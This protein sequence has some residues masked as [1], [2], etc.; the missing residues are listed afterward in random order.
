MPGKYPLD[1]VHYS[2]LAVYRECPA[3]FKYMADG[4]SK[5]S[6]QYM[7]LGSVFHMAVQDCVLNNASAGWLRDAQCHEFWIDQFDTVS[8]LHPGDAY[9]GVDEEVIKDWAHK[10]VN[11]STYYGETIGS[12]VKNLCDWIRVGFGAE[13]IASELEW[14]VDGEPP[15]GGALD[16][17]LRDK[18]NRRIIADVK[19]SGLWNRLL[20]DKSV[21]KQSL[22]IAQVLHHPQL[23]MYHWG[24]WQSGQYALHEIEGYAIIF[25]ANLVPYASGAK[26]GQMRGSPMQLAYLNLDSYPAVQRWSD[27]MHAWVSLIKNGHFH[28]T[29]PNQFGKILCESCPYMDICFS[30]QSSLEVPDYLREET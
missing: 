2:D 17:L 19:T 4:R 20:V 11:P 25:P 9:E 14:R 5:T 7:L 26:K 15:Y 22:S 8:F 1:E 30:D 3:K 21:T 18:G 10:F 29:F 24:L 23:K 27:D 6:S 16:L 28:R 12:L 13:V